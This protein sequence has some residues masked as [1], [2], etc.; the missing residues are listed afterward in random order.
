MSQ[1]IEYLLCKQIFSVQAQIFQ[2]K[3]LKLAFFSTGFKFKKNPFIIMNNY[4]N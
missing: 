2:I 1:L 4:K 3:N